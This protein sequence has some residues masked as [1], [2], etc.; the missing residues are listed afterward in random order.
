M[1]PLLLGEIIRP[2]SQKLWPHFCL[3]TGKYIALQYSGCIYAW[4]RNWLRNA[5]FPIGGFSLW[6][7]I[8]HRWWRSGELEYENFNAATAK[9]PLK[10]GAFILV[11]LKQIS[12]CAYVSLWIS[13]R[14]SKDDV[15]EKHQEK[16][17]FPFR[18]F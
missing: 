16:K 8:Y 9:L 13:T 4:W 14:F 7:G 17:V 10:V 18:W 12:E 1:E 15:P 3:A 5:L 11:M 6:L 2:E